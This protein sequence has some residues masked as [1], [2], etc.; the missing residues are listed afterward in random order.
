MPSVHFRVQPQPREYSALSTCRCL[1]EEGC[2]HTGLQMPSFE[3]STGRRSDRA[4][5]A[6]FPASAALPLLQRPPAA[7]RS[8]ERP[9]R[10]VSEAAAPAAGLHGAAAMV[11]KNSYRGRAHALASLSF[12]VLLASGA[13]QPTAAGSSMAPLKAEHERLQA[14]RSHVH[15]VLDAL[16]VSCTSWTLMQELNRPMNVKQILT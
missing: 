15:A 2:L 8:R 16:L 6:L 10:H 13:E 3:P 7:A 14:C 11:S 5:P 4:P 9:Q 1:P 12:F